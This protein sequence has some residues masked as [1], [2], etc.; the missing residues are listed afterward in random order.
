MEYIIGKIYKD[1]RVA[2]SSDRYMYLGD[3]LFFK[4]INPEEWHGLD[5]YTLYFYTFG[6]IGLQECQDTFYSGWVKT[7]SGYR[8]LLY[9]GQPP[10]TL[11]SM[12]DVM[13]WVYSPEGFDEYEGKTILP[14]VT[15]QISDDGHIHYDLGPFIEYCSV[16]PWK[17]LEDMNEGER[18]T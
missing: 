13:D 14:G 6:P 3:D 1:A 12:D 15:L 16:N 4:F 18:S 9:S 8:P 11:A 2:Y 5:A 10:R 7:P 17:T